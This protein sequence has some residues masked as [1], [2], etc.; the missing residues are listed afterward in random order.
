VVAASGTTATAILRGRITRW[1]LRMFVRPLQSTEKEHVRWNISQHLAAISDGR[2][3]RGV[4]VDGCKYVSSVRRGLQKFKARIAEGHF[5]ACAFNISAAIGRRPWDRSVVRLRKTPHR[6][7]RGEVRESGART[8]ARRETDHAMSR[9]LEVVKQPTLFGI[10]RGTG[11]IRP[12][13]ISKQ[14][15]PGF[16]RQTALGPAFSG[17]SPGAAQRFTSRR[18]GRFS[19]RSN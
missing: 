12:L 11:R 15:R 14:A 8:Q 4:M 17:P 7:R 1:W 16:P 10:E 3:R 9:P 2:M 6:P 5:A 13:A 19:Q 18:W